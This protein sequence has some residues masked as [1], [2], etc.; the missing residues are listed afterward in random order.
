MQAIEKIK[1]SFIS[2][3][4]IMVV[5]VLLHFSI[6][7]MGKNFIPFLIGGVMLIFGLG[8]FLLGAEIALVPVGEKIGSALTTKRNVT[9]LLISGLIIG[10]I[11][12]VAE[13]DVQVL[14]EQVFG[15]APNIRPTLLVLMIGA[16]V[17]FFTSVA[18]LRAV[19]RI[20]LK[21]MLAILYA[22]LFVC[23]YFTNPA[24]LAISFDA[25]G[26]TTG[27][28]TV[29]FIM[30]LGIGIASV[31]S[32]KDKSEDQSFGFIGLASVGPVLSVLI[33]GFSQN[34]LQVCRLAMLKVRKFF[35]FP[36]SQNLCRFYQLASMR[37]S[38]LYCHLLSL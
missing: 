27:P 13:P 33:L 22:G 24:F 36:S 3:I 5:V 4:P 20:P 31:Y 7:P 12:T 37:F 16:G 34:H 1:E 30:S 32:S 15:V 35:N 14:A 18:M 23:A 19:I 10:F 6:A 38:W 28:M 21:P 9:L 8:I 2:V 11:V 17:G 25:G 26:A 29:P